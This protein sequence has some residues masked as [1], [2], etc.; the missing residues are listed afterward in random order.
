MKKVHI[1]VT[2]NYEITLDSDVLPGNWNGMNSELKDE[3]IERWIGA[4]AI[5]SFKWANDDRG[6]MWSTWHE[7]DFDARQAV[8]GLRFEAFK[9]SLSSANYG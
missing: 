8:Q 6:K 9:D 2:I 7:D 4:K 1:E 3:W 5:E